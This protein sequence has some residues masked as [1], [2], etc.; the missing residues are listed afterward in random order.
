MRELSRL[1]WTLCAAFF[2]VVLCTARGALAAAPTAT[3]SSAT[4]ITSTSA[5]LNGAGNPGGE[6]TTGWFR[7]DTT[8]PGTCNDTFGTRV[9]AASGT[10]LG[11]GSTSVAYSITTTG[12]SAGTTYYYCA[13]TQNA[14]GKAYGS[15]V[16]FTI[17][18]APTV[19]TAAASSITSTSATM[20]GS[21]VPHAL[22]TTGWFRYS[23]TAP[24]SCNDSF[25]I[26]MPSSGGTNLGS[27]NS[28]VNFS[29]ATGTLLPGVTYYYCAIAS[30]SLGTSFG[31][32]QSFTTPPA[33]PSAT[34]SAAT[35]IT[36][37]SAVLPGSGI[38]RG[39][40]A[41]GYFRY[42]TSTGTCSDTFG[43]RLPATGGT[44]LG[45]GNTSV[46]FSE[47]LSGL[48]MGTTYFFCA[49][50]TNS[51]GTAYGTVRSFTTPAPPSVT[52]TGASSIGNTTAYIYGSANPNRD[53][54]TG[55]FRFSTT[56]GTC[57][58]TFGI[59][60]PA[61]GGTSLGSGSTATS[62]NQYVT[63]LSLGTTYYYC[64]IASNSLGTA[65]GAVVSFTTTSLAQPTVTTLDAGSITST[66]ATMYG[67]ANPNGVAT[68]GWFRY[69]D[70][71]PVTCNDT[72]GTRMPATSGTSLGSGTSAVN[73]SRATGTLLPGVTYYFCAIA[74]NTY[75]TSF[76]AVQ[77]FTTPPAMPTATTSAA[78][79]ITA[80]SAVLPGSGNPR[81]AAA[82]GYFRY[83]TTS[84]GSC[85]DTFGTRVPATGG[86]DLGSGN[87][88]VPFS[89]SI[90]GLTTGTTYY[91][92]AV[93]FNSVGTAYGSV[94][95]FTTPAAPTVTTTGASGIA[96]TTAYLYGSAN[97]NRD[98]TTGW[99]R[100][101]TTNPGTCNDTF[102]TR[103][104]TTGGTNLGSGSTTTSYSQYVSGL[105]LG[106][107]YYYC[108]IAENSLGK[109]Y[110]AV[111][112][113]TTTSLA[114]PTVTTLDAGSITSTSATMYGS[115]NPNG[116]ATTGWFRYSDTAPTS[117]NDTF[118][119]RMPSS[120]GT[121]LGSGTS[122][123]NFSRATGTLL[124][125]VTYYFCAIASNSYGTSFG[126]VQ[127]F[128]TPP[129]MPTAT[130]SAAT[131]I[132]AS[133]AV[134]PGSGNPR[135]AAATGYF[136]YG[137]TSPGS[138]TDTFG[139]RVP[140]T[141]GT[142]LG[143]GNTSVAFTESIS[144]LTTGTTYYFC[145]VVSS[146]VGTAY[147]TVR[148]FTTP[149][150][151]TVTTTGASSIGNTTAYLYGSANPNRDATTGWFRFSTTNPGTCND[152]F[153]TRVPATGG[154][155]LGSGSTATSYSQYL[156]GLTAGT[157]YY[158]CA[159]AENSLG[160]AYGAVVPFT[161]TSLAQPTVITL[162]AG[163]VTSTSATMY[164]SANPN[165][166][167]T[168]GWFRYSDTNPVT[169][170]DT[171][172]TRMP[173]SSGTSLGS[174]TNAVNFSRATGTLLPGVTY[175]YCAIAS[176]SYGTSFGAVQSFT[177]LPAA[178]SAT[179]SAATSIT[180]S[181]AVL[182]GSGIP[183]G[184]AAT[185]Y[186]RYNTSTGTCSDTFGTRLPATG[187]T[188]LGSGNT[189]VTFSETLSGLSMGTTY[190]F[191][192]V[193][194]NSVGTA[195]G[196]MRSFTTP[197]PPSVTTTGASS[198]GNTTAYIYGSANPNR[199]ATTGWF[200]FSTTNGTCSDTFGIRVPATGGTSLG[201]GSTATSYNQYVTG[202]SLGTTYYYCAIASNSLGTTYG[203]VV[204]F[205]TT[206]LAQPTVTTLDAGSIT[207]T[208]ATMYGSANPNGV[209][210]TGWF[211]YSDTNPVTCNDTFGTRMPSSSGTSLGSGTSAV[212]FSRATGTLLP[213]VTY[214][215]CAI[216]S[217]S[218]GTSFG[219]VQSFTTPPAM[220]T[221]TTSAATSITASSAVLPGSGNPRGAAATGYFRYGTTSPGSCTDT[222][223]TRVP[224]T[225][226]TDLGSGNTSVPFSE[227]ISGLTTG[228]TY[229]F[230][231]VVFNSVGTAYG[232]VRSFTTPAAPTVTTTGASSIGN[233]T[234]YLYG[235]ANPNR[236]TTTGW[237]RFSTTN[238]GTCNDTFGTRVPTTG[239]TNLGS[240]SSATS[241]SQYVSGLS[242][243]TTYY[244]CAI[245]ENS[246]GKAYGAVVSFTTTALAQPTVTTLA[247]TSV[248]STSATM[249]GSANPNGVATTGW[250]RYSDTAP[251]SCNDTFGTRM[252]S[253][254]GTSLGSGTSAVSFSRATGTLLPG[255]TYYFC[256]IASNSYGTSFGTV[257]SFTTPPLSPT[258]TTSAASGIASTAATFNGSANPRG[259]STTGYFRYGTTS[260]GSCSDTFGIRAPAAAGAALGA[261]N[262]AVPYSLTVE[263]L[264]PSTTYYF[265][266][267]A[268][269]SVGVAFGSVRS[270]TTPATPTV[271]TLAATPIT[272]TTA[273]LN[274][275]ATP[276]GSATT[277][278]FRF[279][280]TNPGTCN[281]T[282]GT[283]APSS[284]GTSLGSGS[285]AVSYSQAISSLLPGTTYYFC[286][287]ASNAFGTTLGPV[288]SFTTPVTEGAPSV[289]TLAASG[290]STTAATLNGSANPAG[291]ATTG[292]F[293]YATTSP[294]SCNDTFGVRHPASGGSAL[295]AGDVA[296]SYSRA[297]T[298]LTPNTTY[299]FCAIAQ[300]TIGTSV[301]TVLSFTT[302]AS[303]PTAPSVE[304]AA[305]TAI[306]STSATLN[307]A[308]NPNGDATTGWFR[309]ATTSPSSCNDSFGVRHPASGGSTLG[310][311]TSS[312]PY[313]LPLSGLT[314]NTT[315]YFCAVGSNA[316][317]TAFGSLLSF[318]TAPTL[319]VVTVAAS[320]V[321]ST[322]ATLNGSANPNGDA[323]TGW[324]R[325]ATSSPGIC[326]D[327]FGT[328]LPASGGTALGSGTSSVA[329]SQGL[330]GLS[331]NTTYYFCA[332]AQNGSGTA[333]GSVL[334][335]TTLS[336]PSVVTVGAS[337]VASTSATLDGM[338]N[339]NGQTTTGWF[340]YSTSS[341]TCS[342]SFGTR[343]PASGGSA[344]GSGTSSVSYS[345][346]LSG[347]TPNTT[348]YF[349]AVAQNGT[350]TAFGSVLSF[351]TPSA[352]TVV[353]AGHSSVASTSA[354]LE[355]TANPNGQ[356]TTGW[357]RY[358]TS[359]GTCSDSFGTRLPASGGTALGSGTSSVPYSQTLSSLT[360]NTT[361]YFC[362]V[363]QNGTGTAFGSVLS[364]TTPSA[365]G[366]A[367][368]AA[369]DVA[370][371]SA[372]L[373]G[374]ANP[375]GD[376]TTGWFRYGTGNP[377][378]CN[379]TFGTRVPVSGGTALGAGSTAV[380]YAHAVS[381]L[382]PQTT[383]YFCAI[384]ENGTGKAFGSVLPFTT[385]A[386]GGCTSNAECSPGEYCQEG[387]CFTLLVDGQNCA[388]G[389]QCA[390][391]FCVDGVCC[392]AACG[393]QCQ[394]CDVTASLGICTP[395]TGAPHGS[396]PACAGEGDDCGGTCDG[397]LTTSCAY[398]DDTVECRAPSCT[399]GTAVLA[400]SCD[401]AGACP[402][403]QT[404]DCAPHA[405]G[406]TM[407]A[408]DCL[409]DDDCQA[410]LWCSAGICT[411]LRDDGAVCSGGN[412][413]ISGACVMRSAAT[414]TATA[415]ARP[416]MSQGRRA[417]ACLL[418]ALRVVLARLVPLTD[419]TAAGLVTELA[420]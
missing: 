5:V 327:S 235:S 265:C 14:S 126:T 295:G 417:S 409:T 77:S 22:T 157:T 2:L 73:Y 223:G 17:P 181:S 205:T 8:T 80:S 215:F 415:S 259:A 382:T 274:A 152:T 285:T 89:E 37:N 414:A 185:G 186:F 178:P 250:F 26:R 35:S 361:Y 410:D 71:N 340:R 342:D 358:S 149:A 245:A 306:A 297:L 210:T 308:A 53:A 312:V 43:T 307:G 385:T 383:Y 376:D 400:A 341:G 266:A 324:F 283:R 249:Q 175:Y 163:S 101:S 138:C 24:T 348:Y 315:Y 44:D 379:D 384:A 166:V 63:G 411:L 238:P 380:A 62:Y 301:G 282:F 286:A 253:S 7:Y 105:S 293:R 64:A 147:G 122:A 199:D 313:S 99:F 276:N 51:V 10:D 137:T 42:S 392:N 161:T 76:G 171:F 316:Q 118:G 227:S 203:A 277:G 153:G 156:S 83:G 172:G 331:P 1:A 389:S 296:V 273:T 201:S 180:A 9:P 322:S 394:A 381:G 211:R 275:S 195:Y 317:G 390:S 139:T 288:L 367:T 34:T 222:F 132:T 28:T 247:A 239:G 326:N 360:P 107:T 141:G 270:F 290:I 287:I 123:V 355:G 398:P 214:Y 208:S 176:N 193:V 325:Y 399:S 236:D 12:L 48:S 289:V 124:P 299:Y 319:G 246:L 257:Q 401:G 94:R 61:T 52:T 352:P 407:C 271:A 209:A 110:G 95:S 291:S 78:T 321:A 168:T 148:S 337:G 155:N 174:G 54:T 116:V 19:V 143:S 32:V 55:W 303:D 402:P 190:Y 258:V 406:A 403:E 224:A 198:I 38:P 197:A 269:N 388:A 353:T 243:G 343:F 13:I 189:S 336:A 115:A 3:T 29:R 377:G 191:C 419:P 136:R 255:V 15:V 369:T 93:V 202:L 60:V 241:Y 72:F 162:E 391:T 85:T 234:A 338:V 33:A 91:F 251:T 218:Y 131:S 30:N 284:G 281:D 41:T 356:S 363:A 357:F 173:A 104:P 323:T 405:C 117:C 75:G 387:T 128:T 70:T 420:G 278:W 345:Q 159:I 408:G 39:A 371:S 328:R 68:T 112:S 309:Y 58:D 268:E 207:S 346:G 219:T 158:Y 221:A 6:A 248:T 404:Q 179:T 31:A 56:D 230:C 374:S 335:F 252:P 302:P 111:V 125:G 16:S 160:K 146:S 330:S 21:A 231:A 49:V 98:A 84:P 294:S 334:S 109:A 396:R 20:N 188:D 220:P 82:T 298:G 79:S 359:S 332:I 57:S 187:G 67:S 140:A 279:S 129:A 87:T 206:A 59:R 280:P 212:N 92:C 339:P 272:S 305:A 142:D 226:G 100:F 244:Y 46:T 120:G 413:C 311:G 333:L 368:S 364:F 81:G 365:P 114:Q 350:G 192:A 264:Q 164:G 182:P 233:T 378:T 97:P 217:N 108:A 194:T 145:A 45:S 177:T 183:R 256:A 196:S 267:V 261:G 304:T 150:A 25:G 18:A 204:P 23:D 90:S 135:G 366:V 262:T 300:N 213:G 395:V 184:A 167:A 165:G 242:L 127:S 375:R 4:G 237:F 329:Y 397:T 130:T 40:T 320:S 121:S 65:Y 50:V 66:S 418:P 318:T 263:A 154:T 344:L 351:T 134:L 292:W 11:S 373:N 354:T 106:T 362:A 225:G 88:S 86:T 119:T 69:S 36:A 412:Q 96:N 27:G 144:G 103:V 260:P 102:G 47:T 229:Y 74:S 314:P 372:T 228:T 310:A 216:A 200:R 232:S 151:P 170:N 349:C 133:S 240:G 254:G 169:C 113:F 416:A 393:G 370:D 347:L 386:A